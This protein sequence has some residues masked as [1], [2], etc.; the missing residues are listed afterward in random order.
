M[1]GK[2]YFNTARV[3]YGGEIRD[4]Q[5]SEPVNSSDI[6]GFYSADEAEDISSIEY[7]QLENILGYG[8]DLYPNID[9]EGYLYGTDNTWNSP[10]E[11]NYIQFYNAFLGPYDGVYDATTVDLSSDFTISIWVYMSIDSSNPTS[12]PG[13]TLFGLGK[14]SE[15]GMIFNLDSGNK[16]E[17]L[18]QNSFST[19]LSES[20]V[21]NLKWIYLTVS[22]NSQQ[23]NFYLNGSNMGVTNAAGAVASLT[24]TEAALQVARGSYTSSSHVYASSN[25]YFHSIELYQRILPNS[26]IRKNFLL[27][28]AWLQGESYDQAYW[29]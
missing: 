10:P 7:D 26:E 4:R 23:I 1:F 9:Y 12:V 22:K 2:G 6:I 13:S 14:R 19:Y 28:N 18:V 17:L 15:G 8:Y 16:M 24:D 21:P 27:R 5:W 29:V 11:A 3:K 20:S 25:M